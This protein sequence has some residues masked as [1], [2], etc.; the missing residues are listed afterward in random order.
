MEPCKWNQTVSSSASASVYTMG[1]SGTIHSEFR[2]GRCTDKTLKIA[3]LWQTGKL[4]LILLRYIGLQYQRVSQ[5]HREMSFLLVAS[6]MNRPATADC[7]TP[8]HLPS[9]ACVGHTWPYRASCEITLPRQSVGQTG[10]T[11]P[12]GD[13]K[14]SS[15]DVTPLLRGAGA[16]STV[17]PPITFAW[18]WRGMW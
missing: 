7:I 13:A 15:S 16:L 9:P 8:P 4:D 17:V 18:G 2:K 5:V 12:L 14:L 3:S 6:A 1:G 11:P 10:T